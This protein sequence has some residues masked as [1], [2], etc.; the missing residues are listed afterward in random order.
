MQLENGALRSL[1]VATWLVAG[2]AVVA[3]LYFARTLFIPVTLACVIGLVLAPIVRMLCRFGLPRSLA[4]AL[5]V[6]AL[7][8]VVVGILA[9]LSGPAVEWFSRVPLAMMRLRYT[10]REFVTALQDM[11][12][13][14]RSMAQL[15]PGD[16]KGGEVVVQGPDLAQVFLTNT[17][18]LLAMIVVTG[19]LLFFLL[20]NGY[21]FLQK[22]VHVL[23]RFGDKKR[24]VEIGRALQIEVSRY[25]FT[26]S[27]INVGLGVAT[28]AVT[29]LLGLPDPLLWGVLATILNFIPYAGPILTLGAILL[30]SVVTFST[31]LD[32]F[33]PPMAFGLLTA[34]EGNVITPLL[35]G[36]SLTLNPVIVFISL[37]LWGWLWGPAGMLL[38]VPLLVIVK[39]LCDHI[40]P[41]AV[42]GEYLSSRP[43]ESAAAAASRQAA[44]SND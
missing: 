35:L 37:L 28:S 24:A 21:L 38:A 41:L 31:P 2:L 39:I 14:T 32:V 23:P 43:P 10:F 8:L 17:G 6:V 36:R 27:A 22:T 19:I 34:L 25:L 18:E 3:A 11:Q 1:T 4:S 9:R 42:V 33:L 12:E 44:E 40:E 5:V 20:A 7:I 15:A 30:A 16:S 26:I 29:F 13:F